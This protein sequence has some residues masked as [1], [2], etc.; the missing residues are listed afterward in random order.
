MLNKIRLYVWKHQFLAIFLYLSILAIILLAT[1]AYT[2]Y[3]PNKFDIGLV[4][5]LRSLAY[6]Q[7]FRILRIA[8]KDIASGNDELAEN[9]LKNFIKKTRRCSTSTNLDELRRKKP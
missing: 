6:G 3:F 8:Q 1:L 5:A 9:R 4:V 2:Y 7:T